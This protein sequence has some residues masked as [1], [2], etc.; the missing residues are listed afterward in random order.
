MFKL[1]LIFLIIQHF[2]NETIPFHA[3]FFQH[4]EVALIEL[5]NVPMGISQVATNGRIL[6]ISN[7]L[8]QMAHRISD[9]I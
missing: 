2:I 9:V 1:V 6:M 4:S 7:A 5:V 8:K 3:T